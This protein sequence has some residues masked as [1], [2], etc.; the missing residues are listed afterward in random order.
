MVENFMTA[1]PIF[2][3]ENY[4]IWSFKMKSYLKASGLWDVVMSE[5]HKNIQLQLNS[6]ITMMK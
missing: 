4:Q 1:P 2:S 3:G 6:E 5:I